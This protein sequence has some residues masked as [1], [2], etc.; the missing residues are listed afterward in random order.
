LPAKQRLKLRDWFCI[1]A[2]S[3]H[4]VE[5]ASKKIRSL[6]FEVY[7]PQHLTKG[8]KPRI[9]PVFG[10]YFFVRFSQYSD[11]W[12][13]IWYQSG[14]RRIF[15]TS[16]ENPC[17]IRPWVLLGLQELYPD[18]KLPRPR[19]QPDLLFELRG[20]EG[21]RFDLGE[22][23]ELR[24]GPFSGFQGCIETKKNEEA[25]VL[26]GIFGQMTSVVVHYAQLKSV[27]KGAP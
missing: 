27:S 7:S 23:V 9:M 26:L 4:E 16:P 11:N 3:Y 19:L 24:D 15:S 2:N 13:P 10:S 25:I 1:Q 18:V 21:K 22:L 17:P 12:R 20:H 14:V 8:K 6:G 5:R